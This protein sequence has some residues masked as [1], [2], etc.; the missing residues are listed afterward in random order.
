MSVGFLRSAP[1]P[2]GTK[3]LGRTCVR[4]SSRLARRQDVSQER[5]HDDR[6]KVGSRFRADQFERLLLRPARAIR[7]L[8]SECIVYIRDGEDAGQQRDLL[9]LEAAG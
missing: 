1:H 7:A 8:G 5:I 2:R 3:S 4:H 6:I 9:P